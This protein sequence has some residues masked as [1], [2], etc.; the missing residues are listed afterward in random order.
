MTLRRKEPVMKN[1]L[2]KINEL[3]RTTTDVQ[4]GV[5]AAMIIGV[6]ALVLSGASIL[7]LL[8]LVIQ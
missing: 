7:L 3:R 1:D 2:A 6:G 8:R 5:I 4:R